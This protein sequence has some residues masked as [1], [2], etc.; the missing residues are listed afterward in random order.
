MKTSV[1]LFVCLSGAGLVAG[2]ML[3]ANAGWLALSLCLC[4]GFYL[5][6]SQAVRYR[7]MRRMTE[8]IDQILHGNDQITLASY[9]EGDLSILQNELTKLVARLREQA[10]LLQKEKCLMADSIADIS[11]QI[12]TPL[13]SVNL[14][15]ESIHPGDQGEKQIKEIEKQLVRVQFLVGSLLKMARL[16][17][18]TIAFRQETITF[19]ELIGQVMAPFAILMEL[20]G[21]T[22]H[23]ELAG[24]YTGDLLWSREAFGNIIKN[25]IDHMEQGQL[26]I[27][28]RE[29]PLFSE[30]V[31]RDTGAGL[32]EEDLV[33]LF[34]RFYRGKSASDESVGI[35]LSLAKKIIVSQNGTIKAENHKNGG[36]MFTVRFYKSVV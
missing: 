21:Q 1:L 8:E 15:L 35:G 4:F 20:K 32:D 31:I 7:H 26:S 23:T 3:H 9:Q 12:R 24:S 14:M 6:G 25:C 5:F 30:I 22:L 11:H 16:D 10:D 17:A 18:G 36:A 28:S 13:T 27:Q 2:F 29:N 34:D 33:R 19:E